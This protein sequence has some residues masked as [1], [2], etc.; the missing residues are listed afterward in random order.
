MKI[1]IAAISAIFTAV[2]M[3][4]APICANATTWNSDDGKIHVEASEIEYG[5]AKV[6]ATGSVYVKSIDKETGKVFEA[7][8]DKI[9]VVLFSSKTKSGGPSGLESVKSADFI[10]HSKIIYTSNEQG[11]ATKTVAVADKAT[12]DGNEQ[13][14]FLNGNVKITNENQ[15]LFNGPTVMTGDKATINLKHTLGPD[16]FRFKVE[17]INGVS[18]IEATPKQKEKAKK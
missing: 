17:T 11:T 10:G 9:I 5:L 7:N 1:K 4:A 8:A 16:D 3:L 18:K 6:T 14:A 2:Y 12:Y 15:S 13:L